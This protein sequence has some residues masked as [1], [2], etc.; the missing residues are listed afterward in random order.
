MDNSNTNSN[1]SAN[2]NANNDARSNNIINNHDLYIMTKLNDIE[3][4]IALQNEKI[5]EIEK[6]VIPINWFSGAV[7]SFFALTGFQFYNVHDLKSPINELTV[8][9]KKS[10]DDIKNTKD[11]LIQIQNTSQDMKKY[12][13]SIKETVEL[14]NI[15]GNRF[16]TLTKSIQNNI[17]A[18]QIKTQE[19][20]HKDDELQDK[21]Q[22]SES[23]DILLR[24]AKKAGLDE[25][26]PRVL[27]FS[28]Y[29]SLKLGKYDEARKIATSV[30]KASPKE[31]NAYFI[32]GQTYYKEEKYDDAISYYKKAIEIDPKNAVYL[33]NLST[34]YFGL[35]KKSERNSPNA[36]PNLKLAAE[37]ADA[38]L[39]QSPNDEDIAYNLA[40]TMNTQGRYEEV[41]KRFNAPQYHKMPR[42]MIE[43][44]IAKLRS[45]KTSEAI[46]IIRDLVSQSHDTALNVAADPDLTELR[47]NPDFRSILE[48]AMP[49]I[50]W[51][52]TL[53]AWADD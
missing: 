29:K 21:S 46:A 20:T 12:T 9:F 7:V 11:S 13:E 2:I 23:I 49:P 8:D 35:W 26:N 15:S 42:L 3:R 43:L 32:I 36:D 17:N 14:M 4:S 38:A 27:L 18:Q 22:V 47:T 51:K 10:I 41:S 34:A 48:A 50:L 1:D 30:I 40:G 28:A 45:K 52:A 44:S 37:T 39:R 6:K 33:N 31:A 25:N 5:D 19:Q 24:A 16:D 53:A